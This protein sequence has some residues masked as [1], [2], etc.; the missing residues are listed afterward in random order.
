MRSRPAKN[1]VR[2]VIFVV[3]IVVILAIPICSAQGRCGCRPELVSE[4]QAAIP[5]NFT[6]Q[7]F[8][9]PRTGTTIF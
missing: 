7:P 2:V 6:H 8:A 4:H 9:N 3:V 5:S 1:A